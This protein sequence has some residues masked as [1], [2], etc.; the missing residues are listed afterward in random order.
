MKGY[1]STL[2][3]Q[4][5]SRAREATLSVLGIN[6]PGLRNY[7]SEKMENEEAFLHG[8][9]FEQMFAWERDLTSSMQELADSGLLSQG[10][11]DALDSKD[12]GRYRFNREWYP[13]KHQHKAWSD[14]L[15]AQAQSRI[16]TSGTGSGKTECFM[17]PVLEDLYREAQAAQSRLT[18]VRALFLYPLNALINSQRERLNAWTKHF[19]G[20]IRFCLFNG[21]T[22]EYLEAKERQLQQ[23][24]PQEVMSREGLRD[25][26]AQ[27]LVTNGTM[28]EYML[29]RQADAPIIQHSKGKLRWI[30]LDDRRICLS[31]CM[32][33]TL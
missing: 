24:N 29:I 19:K 9:V 28:L 21:K 20:D 30:V 25:D 8:P 3:Q 22:P 16:I 1:F 15:A 31:E 11:V 14:L 17:I 32:D 26:P 33:E 5:N 13:F 27:I 18:G 23:A 4:A 12:N 6:N 10:V 7:L 2:K